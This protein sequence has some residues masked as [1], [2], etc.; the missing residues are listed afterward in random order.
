M[1]DE[2]I[3]NIQVVTAEHCEIFCEKK[4]STKFDAKGWIMYEVIYKKELN[5]SCT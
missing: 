5:V 4:V 1:L 3:K 2:S